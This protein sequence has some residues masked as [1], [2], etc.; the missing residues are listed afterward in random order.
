MAKAPAKRKT[1][2]KSAGVPTVER[3]IH[4]YRI[5][6][7][8]DEAGNVPPMAIASRSRVDRVI[9]FAFHE[10]KAHYSSSRVMLLRQAGIPI[11]NAHD[12]FSLMM[13]QLSPFDAPRAVR[14]L[15]RFP[16]PGAAW[17]DWVFLAGFSG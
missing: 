16:S 15:F 11:R 3:K 1:V 6:T 8:A 9:R 4:F 12:G 7:G 5:H 2:K 14:T 10:I 17:A 13:R